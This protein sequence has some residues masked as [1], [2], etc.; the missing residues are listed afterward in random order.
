MGAAL[1][2]ATMACSSDSTDATDDDRVPAIA[3]LTGAAASG[4]SLYVSNCTSCH[5]ADGKTGSENRNVASYAAANKNDTIEQIIEGEGTMPAYGAQFSDQEIA[6]LV[7]YTAS[8][9]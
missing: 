3:A 6:D 7:A 9:N 4:S 5:G 2:A 1:A 8:L